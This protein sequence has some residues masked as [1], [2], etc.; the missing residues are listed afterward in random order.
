MLQI[1]ES[2]TKVLPWHSA[3]T[4]NIYDRFLMFHFIKNAM[5]LQTFFS[6]EGV[7]HWQLKCFVFQNI[8]FIELTWLCRFKCILYD[9]SKSLL[10]YVL[11]ENIFSEKS[12]IY[13]YRMKQF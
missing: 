5:K 4:I 7:V 2:I 1:C 10:F 13:I 11:Q 3:F 6:T 8:T 9:T 12:W